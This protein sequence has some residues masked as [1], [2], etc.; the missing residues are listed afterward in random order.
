MP[1]ITQ[2][3]G[4]LRPCTR[5]GYVYHVY[6]IAL[7]DLGVG[8]VPVRDV[9][10]LVEC[11]GGVHETPDLIPQHCLNPL[12]WRIPIIVALGK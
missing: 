9:V 8:V 2:Q 5:K 7:F 6:I 3:E 10:Q 1:K 11:L 4:G 12:W